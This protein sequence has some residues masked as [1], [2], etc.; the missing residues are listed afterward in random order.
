MMKGITNAELRQKLEIIESEINELK[1]LK[2]PSNNVTFL[3]IAMICA[4]F[5]TMTF[6]LTVHPV[7]L[8]FM[9]SSITATVFFIGQYIIAK[10][11]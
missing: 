5:S 6:L 3:S 10:K 11:L 8:F 7:L 4:F 1:K 2:R 9:M